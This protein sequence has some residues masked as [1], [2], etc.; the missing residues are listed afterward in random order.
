MPTRWLQRVGDKV[1]DGVALQWRPGGGVD[2]R[3][4]A[5][6]VVKAVVLPVA[7]NAPL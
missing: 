3:R 2:V 5:E 7:H 6:A 1:G 4:C